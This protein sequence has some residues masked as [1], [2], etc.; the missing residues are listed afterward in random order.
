MTAWLAEADGCDADPA[1]LVSNRM[2]RPGELNPMARH[3]VD[4]SSVEPPHKSRELMWPG[5]AGV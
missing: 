5:A 1:G 3:S 2:P 4:L